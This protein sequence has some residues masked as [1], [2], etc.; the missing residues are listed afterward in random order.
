MTSR[1]PQQVDNVGLQGQTLESDLH[2]KLNVTRHSEREYT[3]P[4]ANAT[5]I[6]CRRVRAIDGTYSTGKEAGQS[7]RRKVELA[8]LK[9]L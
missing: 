3:G 9:I 7:A 6:V 1:A 5:R 2:T 4:H 8:K